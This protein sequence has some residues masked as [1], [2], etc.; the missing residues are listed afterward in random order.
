MNY[1]R[2]GWVEARGDGDARRAQRVVGDYILFV[3]EGDENCLEMWWWV[4][5]GDE[6]V[7]S[8]DAP[9][10]GPFAVDESMRACEDAARA[11]GIEVPSC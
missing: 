4:E 3:E 2:P 6:A 1:L 9:V 10:V 7:T 5:C 8:G 11:L